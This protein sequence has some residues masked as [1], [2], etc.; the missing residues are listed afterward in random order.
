MASR[1]RSFFIPLFACLSILTVQ[2]ALA[3]YMYLDSNGD[4][5]HTAADQVNPLG[6]TTFDIWINTA[7]NRDGSPTVCAVAPEVPVT[8]F[9]YT[10]DLQASGGTV[11]WGTMVNRLPNPNFHVPPTSTATQYS[12][13]Y[14][15]AAPWLPPGLY[16]LASLS[17]SVASGSPGINIVSEKV[18]TSDETAFG[19]GC[20]ASYF[21][22]TMTLGRDWFDVDGLPFGTGGS[23]NQAPFLDSLTAMTLGTGELGFQELQATD[24]DHQPLAFAKQSGPAFMTVMTA[25]PGNGAARGTV[26][27]APTAGDAGDFTGVVS[28]SDGDVSTQG[29]FSIHVS[30]GPNHSP[31]IE[32]PDA[33]RVVIGTTPEL[34]LAAVDP[35]GQGITFQKIEGPDF[36]TVATLSPGAGGARGIL[37]LTP[38][39]CDAGASSGV[40][41][42]TDGVTTEPRRLTIDAMTMKPAPAQPPHAYAAE[43]VVAAT[44]DLD[45]DG[46][47]DI[48][49]G[50][51]T[52]R[53]ATLLGHGDGTFEPAASQIFSPSAEATCI[54]LGD[55]N[56]DGHL[57]AAL[58]S[59]GAAQAGVYVLSGN[60]SGSLTPAQSFIGGAYVWNLRPS[61]LD[62]D[63]D[64]DLAVTDE[65]GFYI[66]FNHGDGTFERG[67]HYS[68]GG[69]SRG[70]VL[71]DLNG[72]GRRDAL[73]ANLASH[74]IV[75]R[76]GLGNALFSEP[77]TV[78]TMDQPYAV[79]SRD[80]DRDGDLDLA[81]GAF[82]NGKVRIYLGDGLGGFT[83]GPEL[84]GYGWD[85]SLGAC[86]IDGDGDD[87]LVVAGFPNAVNAPSLQV[88]YSNGNGTFQPNRVL[89]TVDAGRL[90]AADYNEDGFPDLA[91]AEG[92]VQLWL[93]DAGGAGMPAARAFAES[94][95]PAGGK[96]TTCVRLEPVAGSYKNAD[97][98]PTSL[99]LS[100]KSGGGSV[101]AIDSKTA[102]IRDTDGNGIAELPV[103]FS[104]DDL[105]AL[106]PTENGRQTVAVHLQGALVDG[107]AFCAS[108]SLDI[109][110]TGKKLTASVSP[111]PL[112]P[113][114]VLRLTTSRDGFLRVRLFDLQGR[115]IRTL[116]DRAMVPAGAH[117]IAI[118]GRNSV[119]QTLA[120]G[121]YFYQVETAEG[122]LRGRIT[123][124]K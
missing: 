62:G 112:N 97:V 89:S 70:L 23:P 114:G 12:D 79:L 28:V 92:W 13:G 85:L 50:G 102:V 35:D 113:G 99:A 48:V 122:S 66:L 43:A 30:A 77:R 103:C 18:L 42:A 98:D 120:S 119:G 36:M 24:A 64:L 15:I 93:N 8:L 61:D 116:E 44:G 7:A 117:H 33:V 87:D 22:N 41:G 121:I 80:W 37:R 123:V 101:H 10:L 96:P 94:N 29:S 111:N 88:A 63:G 54:A 83:A 17:I 107:R 40:I 118:D 6:P 69:G 16:L 14:F 45:G 55:W 3:Q 52:G 86:D 25:D 109:I 5:I 2:P 51:Y 76:F 57:D 110:G 71:E 84:T 74:D 67:L 75:V 108:V 81:V 21:D 105:A 34:S 106:F 46:H 53:V 56:R 73:V 95:A 32:A 19:S 124:L 60:G 104:R 82:D 59:L 9:S 47:A 38:G 100:P 65:T 72:D 58:T 1:A 39:V 20:Y 31:S 90:A 68:M 78:G 4:G 26:V 49:A 11:T 115:V 91:M 27:L